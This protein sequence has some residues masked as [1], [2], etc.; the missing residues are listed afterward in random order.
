MT[1]KW[2]DERDAPLK[3][4]GRFVISPSRSLRGNIFTGERK[5][6]AAAALAN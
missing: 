4:S 1:E 3:T 6:V 5:R 2:A